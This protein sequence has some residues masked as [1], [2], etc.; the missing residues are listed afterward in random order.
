MCLLIQMTKD[1]HFT[2]EFLNGV[3]QRNSDGIGIMWSDGEKLHYRKHLP[4]NVGDA[5]DFFREYAENKDCCVHFR[6]KTH[7]NIDY[8]N[9]HPYPVFG[10]D[11]DHEHPMLLMHNGVLSTGNAKDVTKSDTWHFINDHLRPLLAK[12]PSIVFEPELIA[13]LGKYIGNNRFAI[14]DYAG[15]TAIINKDQGVMYQGA[16]LSN[17]YAWDYYELHPDAR[18]SYSNYGSSGNYGS[19]NGFGKAQTAWDTWKSRSKTPS[20]TAPKKSK[21][22][23]RQKEIDWKRA[24]SPVQSF[25]DRLDVIAPDVSEGMMFADMATAIRVAGEVDVD[26]LIELLEYGLITETEFSHAIMHPDTIEEFLVTTNQTVIQGDSPWVIDADD[27][28]DDSVGG[29]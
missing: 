5:I 12:Y 17:T 2:D 8:L 26:E 20:T 3:Y 15:N 10:F 9:C 24:I 28:T 14:M 7:G 1:V 25:M 27:V 23:P 22:R 21:G 4:R 29:A 6:M 16:W 11:E 13:M 19:W 18:K